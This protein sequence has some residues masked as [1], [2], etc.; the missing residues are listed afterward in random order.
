MTSWLPF[1][2]TQRLHVKRAHFILGMTPSMHRWRETALGW[3][4]IF[5]AVYSIV[6]PYNGEVVSFLSPRP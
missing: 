1:R 2:P 6:R 5:G 3:C 4:D